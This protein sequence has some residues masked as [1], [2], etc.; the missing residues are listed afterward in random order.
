MVFVSEEGD[1]AG[2]S[3][4]HRGVLR[5]EET[6]L[7]GAVSCARSESVLTGLLPSLAPYSDERAACE[8]SGGRR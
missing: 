4:V 7:A 3:R 2:V 8:G 6:S 5:G 1:G